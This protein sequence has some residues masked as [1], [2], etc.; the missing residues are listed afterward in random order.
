[1]RVLLVALLAA[2]S[3]AQ[4]VCECESWCVWPAHSR[5]PACVAKDPNLT[6]TGGQGWFRKTVEMNIFCRQ[7]CKRWNTVQKVGYD[8]DLDNPRNHR[9]LPTV[10]TGIKFEDNRLVRRAEGKGI[11]PEDPEAVQKMLDREEAERHA[12]A[13]KMELEF[14]QRNPPPSPPR[15]FEVQ[16]LPPPPPPRYSKVQPLP[17]LP[18][19][20]YS[21]QPGNRYAAMRV[22]S[23]NNSY[24]INKKPFFIMLLF[25]VSIVSTFYYLH[26][27]SKGGQRHYHQIELFLDNPHDGTFF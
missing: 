1:M 3:Y 17:P 22:S 23:S 19:Q 13:R 7:R 8:V 10:D 5:Y 12:H 9:C 11:D 2:I 25:L 4:T 27:C 26:Q 14:Q 20:P 21:R 16:P 15:Y 24:S 18:P 6:C